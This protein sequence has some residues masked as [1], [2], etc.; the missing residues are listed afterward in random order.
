V[1]W[2]WIIGD[3]PLGFILFALVDI[4]RGLVRVAQGLVAGAASMIS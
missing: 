1:N 3:I 2:V 4:A